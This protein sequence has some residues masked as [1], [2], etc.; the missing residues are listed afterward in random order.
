MKD[1]LDILCCPECKR[2]LRLDR[3]I[4]TPSGR[5]KSGV[6]FCTHCNDIAGA[7]R[8]FKYDFRHFDRA[9]CDGRSRQPVVLERDVADTVIPFDDPRLVARGSWEHWD[10][11]Y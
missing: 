9:A 2:D 5:N 6:L 3:R 7:L 11:K 8:N 10:G 4:V 1:L